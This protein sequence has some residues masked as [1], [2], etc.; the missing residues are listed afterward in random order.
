MAVRTGSSRSGGQPPWPLRPRPVQAGGSFSRL[1]AACSSPVRLS[2]SD[3]ALSFGTSFSLSRSAI[4]LPLSCSSALSCQLEPLAV[5]APVLHCSSPI[6]GGP[7]GGHYRLTPLMWRATDVIETA[8]PSAQGAGA[9][10]IARRQAA[11]DTTRAGRRAAQ[12]A[13]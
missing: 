3:S 7:E 4:R 12:P 11:A 13:L 8:M 5:Y 10:Q 2:S 1:I 6:S 9:F